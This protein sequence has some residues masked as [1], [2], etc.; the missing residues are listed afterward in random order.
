MLKFKNALKENALW[1]APTENYTGYGFFPE[2]QYDE[3]E[4]QFGETKRIIYS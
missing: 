4:E 1:D 3:D 2:H